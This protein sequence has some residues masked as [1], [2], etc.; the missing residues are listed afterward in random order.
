MIQINVAI[1]IGSTLA[2][3][4]WAIAAFRLRVTGFLTARLITILKDKI[5]F[6]VCNFIRKRSA[7]TVTK[8]LRAYLWRKVDLENS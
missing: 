5:Q 7:Y 6:L 3:S 4:A 8:Q 1:P 2:A